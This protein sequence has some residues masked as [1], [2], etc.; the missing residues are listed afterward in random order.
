MMMMMMMMMC[1]ILRDVRD[2]QLETVNSESCEVEFVLQLP[3]LSLTHWVLAPEGASQ[4]H[5]LPN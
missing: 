2:G 5:R 1:L 3:R 4:L